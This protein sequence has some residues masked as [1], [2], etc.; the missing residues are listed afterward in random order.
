MS[1]VE[2]MTDDQEV[3]PA[4]KSRDEGGR[5]L[6][7]DGAV[8]FCVLGDL[9][10]FGAY[11]TTY[12]VFRAREESSFIESAGHLNL[13]LGFF[14]TLV[15]LAS[16]WFVARS[17]VA[18]RGQRDRQAI[19][20]A[21][22]GVV[23]GVLFIVVKLYEWW[24]EAS[25]GYTF[26]KDTFFSFYYILSGAHLVHVLIGLVILAVV[27]VHLRLR[28][29]ARASIAEQGATFWHMVDLLWVLIFALLYIIR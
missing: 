14:N 15:L 19:R 2:Q 4:L 26:T 20:F 17:V 18:A 27:V 11:F 6:P 3:D 5:H 13:N 22:G 25:R 9:I 10:I 24:A 28:T 16:S 8:W 12:I 29:P 23:C 1:D 7:G 21:V